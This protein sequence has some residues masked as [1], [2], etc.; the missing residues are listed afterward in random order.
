MKVLK[1]KGGKNITPTLLRWTII[2]YMFVG[3]MMENVATTPIF[4]PFRNRANT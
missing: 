1:I 4:L 3:S 2:S